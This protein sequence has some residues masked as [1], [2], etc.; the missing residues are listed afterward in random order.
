MANGGRI[1]ALRPVGHVTFES[2]L[3]GQMQTN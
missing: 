1:V 2:L 3:I